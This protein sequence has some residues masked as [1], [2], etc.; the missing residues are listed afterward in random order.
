M[1]GTHKGQFL[2][3]SPTSRPIVVQ[4]LIYARIENEQVIESW[5]MIDQMSVL[6]QLGLIPPPLRPSSRTPAES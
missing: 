2:G 3:N 5:I 6:Q 4:G 1:R